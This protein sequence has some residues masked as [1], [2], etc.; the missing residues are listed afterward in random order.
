M[1]GPK[2]SEDVYLRISYEMGV[3][4]DELVREAGASGRGPMV[5]SMLQTIMDED[6]QAEGRAA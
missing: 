4:I 5:R 3:W 1:K 6:K 2:L